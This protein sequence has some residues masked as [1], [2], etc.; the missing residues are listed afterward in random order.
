MCLMNAREETLA[1]MFITLYAYTIHIWPS[2]AIQTSRHIIRNGSK[3]LKLFEMQWISKE[4]F[5]FFVLYFVMHTTPTNAMRYAIV[6]CCNLSKKFTE[7]RNNIC[8]TRFILRYAKMNRLF[9]TNINI[10][11]LC[12]FFTSRT[13]SSNL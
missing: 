6:K 8:G 10:F 12:S 7:T 9:K 4:F 13:F 2:P 1:Y 11:H 5:F 3:F